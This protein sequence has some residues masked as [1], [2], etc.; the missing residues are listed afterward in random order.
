MAG[1]IKET[2]FMIDDITNQEDYSVK[3]ES[4]EGPLDLLL[5]LI[6]KNEIDIYDIPIALIIEQYNEYLDVIKEINLE[7]VGD[8]L[9]MAA[10]LSYIKS[11][12]LVPKPISED[13]EEVEDPREELVRRLIEYQ[14]YK[15]A[16]QNLFSL[17]ILGRDIFARKFEDDTADLDEHRPP[18]VVDLWSLVDAFKRVLDKRDFTEVE[19]DNLVY[20]VEAITVQDKM[21]E[22]LQRIEENQSIRFFNIFSDNS[23]KNE[24]VLTFLALLELIKQQ[25]V[26]AIQEDQFSDILIVYFGDS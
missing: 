4:F 23:T 8:Y 6:K 11:K 17:D 12:M 3:L 16:A 20:T 1:L 9:I 5:H 7:I 21:E 24:I 19:I 14:R 10:E 18:L 13:E 26:K 25:L 15:D 22:I 2:Q